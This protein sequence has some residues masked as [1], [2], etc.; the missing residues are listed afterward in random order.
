MAKRSRK[1]GHL[2]CKTQPIEKM[3]LVKY[4]TIQNNR[5]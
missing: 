5:F 1:N 3:Y 2:Q 4:M